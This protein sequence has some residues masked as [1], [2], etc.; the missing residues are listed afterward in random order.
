MTVVA[1]VVHVEKALPPVAVQ[2]VAGGG[3]V[4]AVSGHL[5]TVALNDASFLPLA[6]SV[7]VD[8]T[9]A[10]FAH[11]QAGDLAVGVTVAFRGSVTGSGAQAVVLATDMDVL[12]APSQADRAAH[13]N[14]TFNAVNGVITALNSD[15]SFT[16]RQ[17]NADGPVA[18]VDYTVDGSHATFMEG[19]ASCLLPLATVQVIG[20]LAGS[21]MTAKIVNV[22]GCAGETHAEP[23]PPATQEAPARK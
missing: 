10:K 12:G 19:K 9:T 5:V 15:G 17:A 4:T 1:S 23:P 2:T 8:D 22:K 16:V 3:K 7:V 6:N 11:G 14:Q 20:S 13:P 18:A 21:S